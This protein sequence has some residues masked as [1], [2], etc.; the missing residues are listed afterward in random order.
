MN[1]LIKPVLMLISL[2]ILG[3]CTVPLFQGDIS[4]RAGRSQVVDGLIVYYSF[5]DV[6]SADNVD[7]ELINS[8]ESEGSLVSLGNGRI[9]NNPRIDEDGV[10]GNALDCS[11]YL[12]ANMNINGG[13]LDTN[14]SIS[15]GF[16]LKLDGNRDGWT[17]ILTTDNHHSDETGFSVV[18]K[19]NSKL[20]LGY[21]GWLEDDFVLIP[22]DKDAW[23]H[24]QIVIDSTKNNINFFINGQ[25]VIDKKATG[26]IGSTDN[27]AASIAWVQ[28][29]NEDYSS[30]ILPEEEW[31]HYSG[32]IDE[33]TVHNR[34]LNISEVLG[35]YALTQNVQLLP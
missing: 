35:V 31:Q 7:R 8:A 29:K 11:G 5:D 9:Y 15:I 28:W 3:A 24:Y 17:R 22:T 34:A 30:G 27:V 14:G 21:P 20:I 18:V 10:Q 1:K 25:K 16:W 23:N 6:E 13:V 19:D 4:G 12:N 32:K 26:S 33:L 2:L